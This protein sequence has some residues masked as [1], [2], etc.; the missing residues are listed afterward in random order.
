M[1]YWGIAH[2][3]AEAKRMVTMTPEQGL[4]LLYDLSRRISM[5]ADDHDNCR[6]ARDLV[7]AASKESSVDDIDDRQRAV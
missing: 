6:M 4:K 7:A 5:P 3:L 1:K 2:L